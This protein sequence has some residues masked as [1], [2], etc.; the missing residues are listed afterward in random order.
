M[1]KTLL[2]NPVITDLI[3]ITNESRGMLDELSKLNDIMIEM[4]N[5]SEP[6]TMI[7]LH[8]QSWESIDTNIPSLDQ[9]LHIKYDI[10]SKEESSKDTNW[11]QSMGYSYSSSTVKALLEYALIIIRQRGMITRI[12]DTLAHSITCLSLTLWDQSSEDILLQLMDRFPKSVLDDYYSRYDL[13]KEHTG[14]QAYEY[15]AR[16]M[17]ITTLDQICSSLSATRSYYP[18]FYPNDCGKSETPC[19]VGIQFVLTASKR[20]RMCVLFR[21]NDMAE[22]WPLNLMGFRRIQEQVLAKARE[23]GHLELG[24]LTTVSINAHVYGTD[25]VAPN[26]VEEDYNDIDGYYTFDKVGDTIQVKYFTRTQEFVKMFTDTNYETLIDN[27]VSTVR[28]PTH[29]AY[30]AKEITKLGLIAR[31]MIP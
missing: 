5:I 6:V 7:R 2:E 20:L 30:I 15:A 28:S 21:S 17:Q 27:V 31:T 10:L 11:P 14:S 25:V 12:R 9:P 23:N 18:L 16:L 1:A 3:I 24:E 29:S 4:S 19:C 13:S 8:H 22:A 26:H